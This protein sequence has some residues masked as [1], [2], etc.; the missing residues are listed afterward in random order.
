MF[1]WEWSGDDFT[2]IDYNVAAY[3]RSNGGVADR[4]GAKASELFSKWP[5]GLRCLK[6]CYA[7]KT[8]VKHSGERAKLASE[9]VQWTETTFVFVPP[10]RVIL[11]SHDITEQ[12]QVEAALRD[13]RE[14]ADKANAAKTRFLA[15]ASHDLRQPLQALTLFSSLL[16]DRLQ[17]DGDRDIVAMMDTS[18][19]AMTDLLNTLLDISKL[20]AGTITPEITEVAVDDLIRS[21]STS[22]SAIVMESEIDFRTVKSHAIVRTDPV[23][24]ERIVQNFAANAIYHSGGNRVLVGC[25]RR[26][27]TLRIEVRDNGK[28]I[29]EDQQKQI[30][31]E[32]YQ[33]DNPAMDR[34][35]GLGLG[36]SIVDRLGRLLNHPIEMS[37]SVG[38]GSMF[39]V[40]LPLVNAGVSM[41]RPP[42][43]RLKAAQSGI[44][45]ALIDDEP[46][47]LEA[48]RMM[49]EALGYDVLAAT[50]EEEMLTTLSS[51]G[52]SPQLIISDYRLRDGEHGTDAIK[53]IQDAV[54]AEIPAM[55]ITGD[56]SPD[57][58]DEAGKNGIRI[59][60]KPVRSKFLSAEIA[61]ALNI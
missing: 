37:S 43:A 23:L 4:L 36:L 15:A 27:D 19:D 6:Q 30:F 49:L 40:E 11:H 5:E 42:T 18:I 57:E 55:I 33:L 39:A 61:E 26:G 1:L 52:S 60:H 32:F 24:T 22:L 54:G 20:E 50:S 53:A 45:I 48:L 2:Q 41:L 8:V 46:D 58:L 12:K 35:K 29:P 56:T 16:E 13:A 59:L 47:V 9:D 10:N 3:V 17:D 21:V 25:R 51:N 31:E 7:E 34:R 14:A 28:G 38:K 44:L